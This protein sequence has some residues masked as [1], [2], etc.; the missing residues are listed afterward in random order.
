MTDTIDPATRKYPNIL[1][2][3]RSLWA[4]GGV[5]RFYRCA[6]QWVGQQATC[7]CA[8]AVTPSCCACCG[9]HC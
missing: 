4:E 2:T 7:G 8:R 5:S 9:V 6:A 3:A 1:S